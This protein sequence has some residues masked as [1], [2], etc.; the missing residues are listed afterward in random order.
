MAVFS[1]L[2]NLRFL[3]IAGSVSLNCHTAFLFA[4]RADNNRPGVPYLSGQA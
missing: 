3:R 2:K 1:L 4:G